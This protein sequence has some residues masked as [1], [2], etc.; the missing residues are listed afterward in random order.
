MSFTFKLILLKLFLDVRVKQCI[1]YP[2]LVVLF[3]SGLIFF[4]FTKK[5]S[6]LQLLK[7]DCGQ[8]PTLLDQLFYL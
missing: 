3:P 6:V 2:N 8:L 5:E 7:V 1:V 4:H